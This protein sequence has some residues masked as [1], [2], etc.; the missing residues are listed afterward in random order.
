[1]QSGGRHEPEYSLSLTME[2][3]RDLGAQLLG[4]TLPSVDTEQIRMFKN[5]V[6]VEW[7]R[8][9]DSSPLI[10]KSIEQSRIRSQTGALVI[11]IVRHSEVIAFPDLQ[12]P[13][14]SGDT[15]IATGKREQIDEFVKQYA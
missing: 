14:Q 6:V 9:S 11:G 7:L 10:G 12:S 13:F 4:I 5:Q 3:A 8:L 2:E 15:L 1:M